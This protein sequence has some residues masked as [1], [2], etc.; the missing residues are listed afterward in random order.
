[1]NIVR[2][3]DFKLLYKTDSSSQG[4]GV[5]VLKK[6]NLKIEDLE[7]LGNGVMQRYINQH[8]FFQDISPN[9]VATFRITSVINNN[10][11]VTINA[12]YLRVGRNSDTHVKSN[13][14]IR[15]PVNVTTGELD[16][17]GY[18][19]NWLRINEHPD[20]KFIFKN[21]IIPHFDEFLTTTVKLHKM[22]PFA[23][24]I[25]WDMIIDTNNEIQVM[26]W[27]GSH[28]DIKFSEATQGPCFSNLGWEELW[29]AV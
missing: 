15:I 23:R 24:C 18:T 7:F 14:H 17:F 20:T 27:N 22:V 10:G 6:E 5:Y 4:K 16:K 12:C 25:G 29:K 2:D 1:M 26:E 11:E 3:E 13:S 19:T 9:S 28:N 8:S 21:R